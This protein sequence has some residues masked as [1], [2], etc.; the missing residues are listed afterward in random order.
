MLQGLLDQADHARREALVDQQPVP[1][2]HRRVHVQHHL[3]GEVEVLRLG[4]AQLGA[5]HPGRVR[6]GRPAH[7]TDVVVPGDRPEAGV[8]GLLGLPVDRVPV[9][10]GVEHAP[11]GDAVGEVVEVGEVHV[12]QRHGFLH[13]LAH[14]G[15][16]G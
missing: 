2:V 16:A 14:G 7:L 10:Q 13:G 9:A 12:V 15:G 6:R 5:A 3:P 11:G 1:R 8:G 4:V